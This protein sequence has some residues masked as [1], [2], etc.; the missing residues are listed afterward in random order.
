MKLH[1]KKKKKKEKRKE[2]GLSK[3]KELKLIAYIQ[4]HCEL[5]NISRAL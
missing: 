5:N 4:K 3:I 2:K 1:K